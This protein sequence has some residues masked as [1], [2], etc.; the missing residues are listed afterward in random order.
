MFNFKRS[1]LSCHSGALASK[2]SGASGASDASRKDRN[3]AALTC[4]LSKRKM[5][6]SDLSEDV[7]C[8]KQARLNLTLQAL[9]EK[10]HGAS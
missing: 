3:L 1:D 5:P 8:S 4:L 7:R 6:A 10:L 9:I 2:P